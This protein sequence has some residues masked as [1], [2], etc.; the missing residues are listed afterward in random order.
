[1]LDPIPSSW[2]ARVYLEHAKESRELA[3]R[4]RERGDEGMALRWE[5]QA[6]EW[7]RLAGIDRRREARRDAGRASRRRRDWTT[8]GG[9]DDE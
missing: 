9:S 6:E 5:R 2:N 8:P 7:E 3:T 1:M 4:A